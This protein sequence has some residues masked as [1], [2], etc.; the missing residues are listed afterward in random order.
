MKLDDQSPVILLGFQRSG[1]TALAYALNEA[2]A[3]IGG[4]FTVNGKLLYYLNRWLT[5]EDLYYRHFRIDEILYSLKR[6][7]P[8]GKGVEIWL[9][10]V[11]NELRK[12][13]LA[14]GDGKHN[15]TTILGRSLVENSYSGFTRWGDKYNEYLHHIP[16]I[17][18]FVPNARYILLYRNP[19]EIVNSVLEWDGDRPWRPTTE[20][21]NLE[22]WANWHTNVLEFFNG[23]SSNRY[24]VINYNH[25]CLSEETERLSEFLELDL[26]PF[27]INIKSRRLSENNHNFP[28]KIE[29][30]WSQLNKLRFQNMN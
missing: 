1:T 30:V 21:A 10:Q 6:K 26:Q 12:A 15:D 13:A 19:F 7:L 27:L 28:S 5:Q 17:D 25:L 29:D 22:K 9:N 8:G 18:K 3:N 14:V 4:I 11:E 23:I 16:Q 20:M 24:I 2:F